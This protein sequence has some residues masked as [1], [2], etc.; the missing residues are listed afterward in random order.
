MEKSRKRLWIGLIVLTFLSPLGIILP[1][2]FN[3]GDAWGEWS[4]DTI[5][6]IFGYVPAGLSKYADIWHAPISD[7]NLWG[8]GAAMGRRILAYIL[9]GILGILMAG[10]IVYLLAKVIFRREN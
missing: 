3:A 9:S 10:S 6:R 7:Y 5:Q 4:I 1:E 2:M 8:D